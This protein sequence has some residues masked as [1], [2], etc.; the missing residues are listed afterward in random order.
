[1]SI[2]QPLFSTQ[3]GA[4][5]YF[6]CAAFYPTAPAESDSYVDSAGKLVSKKDWSD[7]RTNILRAAFEKMANGKSYVNH[8]TVN[9]F[10][11]A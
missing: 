3:E 10:L 8:R 7:R 4:A 1:M 11:N 9:N 2:A 6:K 5:S